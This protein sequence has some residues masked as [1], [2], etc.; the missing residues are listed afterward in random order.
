MIKIILIALVCSFIIIYLKYSKSEYEGL[1]IIA[2]SILL[3]FCSLDYVGQ[4]IEFITKLIYISGVTKEHYKIIIKIVVIA[5]LI[6]F[7][8]M[9]IEDMGLK[10]LANKLIFVGKII[11][12]LVASPVIYSIFNMLSELLI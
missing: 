5:Y 8:S 7:S 11:I 3:I 4:V 2:S 10:S 1:A 6:E 9:T 12:L